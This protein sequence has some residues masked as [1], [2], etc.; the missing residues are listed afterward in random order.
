MDVL[1]TDQR[2]RNMQA[3]KSSGTKS[4]VIL[5]K[6]LWNRGYR[7][8]KNDKSVIGKPDIVFKKNKIAIFC[9]G[10]FWHGKEWEKKKPKISNNKEYWIKK[11]ERNMAR[12]IAVNQQLS[13][14]GW[15]VFRFWHKEIQKN[16]DTCITQIEQEI[17]KRNY[18]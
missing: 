9:D 18:D 8:R 14:L 11:I 3:I 16:L 5:A 12:D 4:E 13:E 6:A 2:R 7:Y 15:K 17:N 10:E 1:N